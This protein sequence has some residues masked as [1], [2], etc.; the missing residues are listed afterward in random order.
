MTRQAVT[1]RCD[2]AANPLDG[3]VGNFF[4]FEALPAWIVAFIFQAFVVGFPEFRTFSPERDAAT[5]LENDGEP[6]QSR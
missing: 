1:Q 6:F 2:S 4:P 3:D 5:A